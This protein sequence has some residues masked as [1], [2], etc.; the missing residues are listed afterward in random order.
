[1]ST[2]NS[3]DELLRLEKAGK[4]IGVTRWAIYLRIRRGGMKG[5]LTNGIMCVKRSELLAWKP[6]KMGRKPKKMGKKKSPANERESGAHD[7]NL[8]REAARRSKLGGSLL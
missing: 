2:P 5:Y 7:P 8:K 3:N 4:A 1:M 6:K